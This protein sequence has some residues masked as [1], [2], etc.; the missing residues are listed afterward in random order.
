MFDINYIILISAIFFL[1]GFVKGVSGIGLPAISLAFLTMFMGIKLA[2]ALVVMPGLLTNFW[3]VFGKYKVK[4]ITLR[5]WPLLIFLFIFSLLGAKVLV[6]N[7][8]LFT[9][10]LGI[11][12]SFYALISLIKKN[13][14]IIPIKYEKLIGA[15][16]GAVGGFFGG[17]T[18]TFIFPLALYVYS[19]KMNKDEFLQTIALVLISA[20][21]FLGIALIGNKLWTVELFLYSSYAVLPSFIG[22]YIGRNLQYIINEVFFRKIFLFILMIIGLLII[23]KAII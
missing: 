21:L 12:L 16:A 17:S 7:S 10:F 3:Q 23:N 11:I 9:L 2:I 13:E 4:K 14:I 20:S 8:E 22:M 1:A 19:L 5:I 18:G 6:N 15:F